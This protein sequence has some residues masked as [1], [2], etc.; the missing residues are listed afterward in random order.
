M[1]NIRGEAN[2]MGKRNWG[3]GESLVPSLVVAGSHSQ[4]FRKETLFSHEASASITAR[5]LCGRG[6][7]HKPAT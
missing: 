5:D 4:E 3:A 2:P 1:G 6:G 7:F